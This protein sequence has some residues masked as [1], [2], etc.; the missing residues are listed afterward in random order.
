MTDEM[1]EKVESYEKF[2]IAPRILRVPLRLIS[3]IFQK[4]YSLSMITLPF[5]CIA[6]L[7]IRLIYNKKLNE[8]SKKEYNIIII[9][10]WFSFFNALVYVFTTSCIDRYVAVGII[11]MVISQILLI[12]NFFVYIK[13]KS[14]RG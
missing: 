1:Y 7:L 3:S 8:Q 10:L 11:P 14:E 6:V 5:L 2:N 9:F 13:G 4:Y 12:K